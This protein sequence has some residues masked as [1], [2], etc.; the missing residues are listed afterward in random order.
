MFPGWSSGDPEYATDAYPLP[1]PHVVRWYEH[2][3]ALIGTPAAIPYVSRTD[4]GGSATAEFGVDANGLAAFSAVLTRTDVG[5]ITLLD[6]ATVPSLWSG[7]PRPESTYTGE[8]RPAS[9][10]SGS[11]RPASVWSAG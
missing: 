1:E 2:G 7:E 11:P 9:T 3:A 4:A 8:A 5:S 10:F 6:A